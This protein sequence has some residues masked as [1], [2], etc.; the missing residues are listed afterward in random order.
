VLEGFRFGLVIHRR[1]GRRASD[2]RNKCSA[3]DFHASLLIED[4]K[5]L[6]RSDAGFNRKTA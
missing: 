4:R 5:I 2:T 1:N 3:I 6:R